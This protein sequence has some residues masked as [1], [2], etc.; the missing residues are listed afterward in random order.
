MKTNVAVFG[1]ILKNGKIETKIRFPQ[2]KNYATDVRL[3]VI[4]TTRGRVPVA[5][6]RWDEWDM[7]FVIRVMDPEY[8][9]QSTLKEILEIAGREQGIGTFRPKFGR[10]EVVDLKPL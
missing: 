10:F 9:D 3:A 5:R 8:L 7:E 6:P 2:A 4:P 1:E